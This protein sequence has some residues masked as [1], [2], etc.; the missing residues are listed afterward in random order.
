MH[1]RLYDAV[2]RLPIAGLTLYFLIREG[3][4]VRDLVGGHPY[5]GGDWIFFM[6]VAARV[7]ICLF[8]VV[9]VVLYLARL[10]PVRKYEQWLPKATA[11]AGLLLIY[12]LL[13]FPR[14]E[15][16]PAWDALSASL[17]IF[18]N[19]L[20]V[21]AALDLGRSLSIMPE[22][23]R[24]V[25]AGLYR[26]IRHPLYLA[27]ELAMVGVFLQFRSWQ[28]AAILIV[29]FYFQLRRMHWEERI[30]DAA[31]PDYAAYR[32]RSWRLVPGVY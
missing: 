2:M 26:R 27:E 25:T 7:A 29:H 28:A 6:Q 17:L 24:L 1:D 12:L 32:Q 21:L 3:G 10:R 14:A 4:A 18:G 8:L 19:G 9:L 20:C 5:F 11:L 30:L 23:R 22:A 16:N 15:A 13:L 31:F